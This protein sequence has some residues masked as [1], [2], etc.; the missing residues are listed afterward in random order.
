M[1]NLL[2]DSCPARNRL[3]IPFNTTEKTPG[4]SAKMPKRRDA[5]AQESMDCKR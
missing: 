2:R 5:A 1:L 3:I 4:G